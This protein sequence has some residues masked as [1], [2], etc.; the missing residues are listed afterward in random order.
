M[1]NTAKANIYPIDQRRD[2]S[3][4]SVHVPSSVSVE[5]APPKLL[6]Q[7]HQ[8]IVVRHYSDDTWKAYRHWTRR[9]IYFHNVRHP[10]DMGGP[11]VE[12]FLTHLAVKE[13]VS[14]STQ[15]QAFNAL[16]FLYTRVIKKDLGNLDAVRAKRRINIPTVLSKDEVKAVMDHLR[17]QYSIIATLLYGAGLRIQIECLKLRVQDLDFTRHQIIVHR[18]KGKKDRVVPMPLII[19]DRLKRHLDQVKKTH[20]QDLRDGFG[21]V[22][23]PDAFDKKSPNA[24]KEWAWQWVF[25]AAT[26]Y[27]IA[28]TLIQ[29][30]HHLLDSAVQKVFKVAV[31]KAGITKRVTPHTLRHCFATHLLESGTNIRTIQEL[32]G[33]Q[34]LNTTMIY[35]HVAGQ[36]SAVTSP[37]DRL[38]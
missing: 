12:S 13:H 9:F 37:A 2:S 16:L 27:R 15:N 6:D 24:S 38:T 20:D 18:G 19:E 29:R 30:R 31:R 11:E 25:P 3:A 36:G 22:E 7:L 10:K 23:M 14:A 26:R 28:G 4:K 33:H 17:G 8:A 32:L 21:A 1:Q 35:T 34:D 5:Q